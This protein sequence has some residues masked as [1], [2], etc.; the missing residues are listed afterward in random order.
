MQLSMMSN[1]LQFLHL[2]LMQVITSNCTFHPSQATD[3]LMRQNTVWGD[4]CSWY[5]CWNQVNSPNAPQQIISSLSTQASTTWDKFRKERDFHR[6]H[7]KRVAQEKNKLIQ[8]MQILKKH[9]SMVT[10]AQGLLSSAQQSSKTF[11]LLHALLALHAP[12]FFP[13][14]PDV[15]DASL[16]CGPKLICIFTRRFLVPMHRFLVPMHTMS[17]CNCEAAINQ[18]DLPLRIKNMHTPLYRTA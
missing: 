11:T 7:H 5:F 15:Q 6:M 2:L 10:A 8:D 3:D 16:P 17:G 12:T 18:Q 14:S 13:H 4:C 1:T 9:C